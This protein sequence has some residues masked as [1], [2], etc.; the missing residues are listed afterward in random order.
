M[1]SKQKQ[2]G[3]KFKVKVALEAIRGEKTVSDISESIRNLSNNETK[4]VSNKKIRIKVSYIKN[5]FSSQL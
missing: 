3:D 5:L 1:G 2:Y 4:A